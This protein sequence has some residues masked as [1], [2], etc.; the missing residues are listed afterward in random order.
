MYSSFSGAGSDVTLSSSPSTL[1]NWVREFDR[2]APELNVQTYYGT[3][4]ERSELRHE[5]YDAPFDVLVTTYNFAG[6]N[7]H[8]RKFFKKMKWEVRV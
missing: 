6:G 2:F 1:E 3:Q 4:N 8:D 5:L 7:E